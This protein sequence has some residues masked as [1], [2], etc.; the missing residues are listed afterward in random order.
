MSDLS[1]PSKIT[2]QSKQVAPLPIGSGGNNTTTTAMNNMNTQLTMLNAQA[3]MDTK[4]D[5]K[6]PKHATAQ[7]ISPFCSGPGISSAEVLGVI[8]GLLI[9]YGIVAK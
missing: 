6:P 4:Y 1:D 2:V 7:V 9:V 3:T 5:P 8:G